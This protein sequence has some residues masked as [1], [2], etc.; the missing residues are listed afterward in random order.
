VTSFITDDGAERRTRD[1]LRAAGV[2]VRVAA[3]RPR[4]R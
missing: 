1:A 3:G 2:D 4:R